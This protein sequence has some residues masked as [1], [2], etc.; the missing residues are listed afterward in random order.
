LSFVHLP[1]PKVRELF[2]LADRKRQP[3]SP[4]SRS[5]LR[6]SHCVSVRSAE[7]TRHTLLALKGGSAKPVG[8]RELHAKQIGTSWIL[9]ADVS[10]YVRLV[11]AASEA[12]S[13]A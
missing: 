7:E 8:S 1:L 13:E 5:L 11:A 3:L 4:I 6:R 9:R 12:A 10:K 2:V